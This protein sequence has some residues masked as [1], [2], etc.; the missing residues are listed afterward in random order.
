MP[1]TLSNFGD[2]D[3]AVRASHKDNDINTPIMCKCGCSYFEEVKAVQY[4][5]NHN[6]II[7]QAVPAV[8]DGGVPFYLLRC[9]KC[10][11]LIEPRIQRM[12]PDSID[13]RYE[14]F[15]SEMEDK[16]KVKT[17]KI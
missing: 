1:D 3:R 6:L 10:K 9:L 7:G 11:E 2:F 16:G 4:M 5:A 13:R 8:Q 17:E 12:N 14:A 15:L